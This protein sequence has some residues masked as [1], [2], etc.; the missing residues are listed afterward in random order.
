ML[1]VDEIGPAPPRAASQIITSYSSVVELQLLDRKVSNA[2]SASIEVPVYLA[3]SAQRQQKSAR[4][5]LTQNTNVY[6]Q[7][8][9]S[10]PIAASV[11]G[12]NISATFA[13]DLTSLAPPA[14][15]HA[16]AQLMMPFVTLLTVVH[17]EPPLA[18]AASPQRSL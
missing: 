11:T 8:A 10:D 4:N 13:Y 16:V 18:A 17:C 15:V 6:S 9:V 7:T 2:T 1:P 3:T 5:P 14:H 12:A